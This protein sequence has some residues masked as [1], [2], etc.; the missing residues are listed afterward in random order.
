MVSIAGS[1]SLSSLLCATSCGLRKSSVYQGSVKKL[2]LSE[3]CTVIDKFVI[4]F[5]SAHDPD[6]VMTAVKAQPSLLRVV[7]DTKAVGNYHHLQGS[8]CPRQA[9]HCFHGRVLT[10]FVGDMYSYMDSW[11]QAFG[12]LFY[13]ETISA[14]RSNPFVLEKSRTLTDI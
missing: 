8:R 4:K 5:D 12:V 9:V 13:T 14:R 11:A 6:S 3:L 10:L 2:T 7:L 1:P